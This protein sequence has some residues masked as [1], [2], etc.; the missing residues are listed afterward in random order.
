MSRKKWAPLSWLLTFLPSWRRRKRRPS[1]RCSLGTLRQ[2]GLPTFRRRP[3][4]FRVAKAR[5]YCGYCD[6]GYPAA[7]RLGTHPWQRPERKR[8]H[9]AR[10]SYVYNRKYF[11]PCSGD[12]TIDTRV[13]DIVSG[14]IVHHIHSTTI[15]MLFYWFDS[16]I[17]PPFQKHNS[18]IVGRVVGFGE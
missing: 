8:L 11:M 18:P 12:S 4:N 15:L 5:G 3:S 9:P 14:D 2:Q 7:M 6:K 10:K 17:T 16:S 1:S 13:G